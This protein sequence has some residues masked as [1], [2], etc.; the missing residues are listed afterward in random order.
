MNELNDPLPEPQNPTHRI[1]EGRMKK[2][3]RVDGTTRI[4]FLSLPVC[5]WFLWSILIETHSF[6]NRF[7]SFVSG[8]HTHPHPV[9]TQ[10]VRSLSLDLLFRCRRCPSPLFL[11]I[12]PY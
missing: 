6:L 10:T 7:E 12:V 9:Q 8:D 1:V 3:K 2:K 11:S 4:L 5:V